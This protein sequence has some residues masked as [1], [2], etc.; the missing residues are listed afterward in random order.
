MEILLAAAPTATRQLRVCDV[1]CGDGSDLATWRA[2]GVPESMLAGTEL[3]AERSALAQSRLP[4]ADI[5]EVAAFD[6]PFP[7]AS[8][9][10]CTA[11]LVLSSIKSGDDRARLLREMARVT[12]PGGVVACYD[13][14]ISKP[15]NRH[16]EAVTTRELTRYWRSPDDIRL[17]AP[18]LPVLGAVLR[19]PTL[20][21]GSLI[22]TLPRTHRVWIWR[23]E[24]SPRSPDSEP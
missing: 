7:S 13:F 19:L 3:V 5:R 20:I 24:P 2:A 17:A 15:W 6:V 1:G 16:V 21:R 9:D 22:R 23:V 11:S 12:R 14:V 18:F 4:E 10:L 8:F